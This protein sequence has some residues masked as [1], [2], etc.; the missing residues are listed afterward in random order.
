[1]PRPLYQRQTDES[2]MSGLFMATFGY[3]F[4]AV[5][6][7]VVATAVAVL[8]LILSPI[9][10]LLLI[11]RRRSRQP[12]AVP[13]APPL[14]TLAPFARI[15]TAASPGGARLELLDAVD[16][17]PL[18]S[19]A[20][21]A[22]AEIVPELRA[23]VRSPKLVL[24]GRYRD[25]AAMAGTPAQTSELQATADAINAHWPAPES[26]IRKAAQR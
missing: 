11:G 3:M 25:V 4:L 13:V 18:V 1:M 9:I 19:I 15:F 5:L 26:L 20:E 17:Q 23:G 21:P 14:P 22:H 24:T 10:I 8:A 6:L 2:I 12:K 7:I 16:R